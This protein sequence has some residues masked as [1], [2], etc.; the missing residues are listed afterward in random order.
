MICKRMC[1]FLYTD[2]C[3]SRIELF[4][5]LFTNESP[6]SSFLLTD[7][8]SKIVYFLKYCPLIHFPPLLLVLLKIANW[9]IKKDESQ[10]KIG[11][12]F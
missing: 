8:L 7:F 11:F 2:L 3:A 9:T 1:E 10:K 4:G 6:I 12:S 5:D